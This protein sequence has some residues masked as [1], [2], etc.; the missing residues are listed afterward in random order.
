MNFLVRRR[1]SP[2]R[3]NNRLRTSHRFA[4][5]NRGGDPPDV[6][7]ESAVTDLHEAKLELGDTKRILSSRNTAF[8]ICF[9]AFGRKP[10][11]AGLSCF[12][13]FIGS[14]GTMT[15]APFSQIMLHDGC[16]CRV[17]LTSASVITTQP[18]QAATGRQ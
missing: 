15:M 11:S 4:G 1:T 8:W 2:K 3:D 14:V 6:L 18:A 16:L 9:P 12:I 10:V 13:R 5:A 7:L 17:S